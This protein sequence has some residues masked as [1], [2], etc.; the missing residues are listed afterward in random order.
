MA[1]FG[2]LDYALLGEEFF[3]LTSQGKSC[4][5]VSLVFGVWVG[6]KNPTMVWESKGL[7]SM[8][9][10][11]RSLVKI[12]VPFSHVQIH[13][14]ITHIVPSCGVKRKKSRI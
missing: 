11:G 14:G 5:S 8:L 6:K 10:D 3:N 12:H 4:L 2:V 9:V 13:N 7:L 1:P